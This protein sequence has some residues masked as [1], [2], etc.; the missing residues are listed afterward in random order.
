MYMDKNINLY[1]II[2]GHDKSF[3]DDMEDKLSKSH[4]KIDI[5]KVINKEDLA[6]NLNAFVLDAI[7]FDYESTDF[8]INEASSLLKIYPYPFCR[9]NNLG[10]F[11]GNSLWRI[12]IYYFSNKTGKYG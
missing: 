12:F 9:N 11:W 3:I 10:L 2:T 5:K 8:N 4:G 7:I 6:E 1:V